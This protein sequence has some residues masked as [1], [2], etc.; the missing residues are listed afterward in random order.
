[1]D[2]LVY[3]LAQELAGKLTD[4]RAYWPASLLTHW[5]EGQLANC[6]ANWHEGLL[7]SLVTHFL[8]V[9]PTGSRRS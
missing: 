7:A 9:K 5:C 8:G 2:Q 3:S 4:L 1:M 6:P